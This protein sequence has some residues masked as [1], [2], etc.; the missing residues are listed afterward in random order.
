[1]TNQSRLRA[2]ARAAKLGAEDRAGVELAELLAE[3]LDHAAAPTLTAV[4]AGARI[5]SLE[6]RLEVVRVVGPQYLRTLTALGLTRAGR[7]AAPASAVPTSGSSAGASQDG[8]AHD[9][10]RQRFSERGA[11]A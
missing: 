1:M 5:L 11:G 6:D 8:A 10:H 3:L 9:R 7:G 2:S 4:A